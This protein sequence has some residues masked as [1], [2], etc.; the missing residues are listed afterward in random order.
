MRRYDM[1]RPP[2]DQKEKGD[3]EPDGPEGH[4]GPEINNI[5]F[6]Q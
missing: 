3:L 6:L 5:F 2:G 4:T 1:Q